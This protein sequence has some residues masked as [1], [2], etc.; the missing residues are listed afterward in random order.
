[1][2]AVDDLLG[3]KRLIIPYEAL[4]KIGDT[5]GTGKKVYIVLNT[6]DR[7]HSV[8]HKVSGA[9]A[10]SSF[11]YEAIHHYEGLLV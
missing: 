6:L 5:Y 8:M 7:N 11:E 1:M 4:A 10:G 3:G 9:Q 2:L